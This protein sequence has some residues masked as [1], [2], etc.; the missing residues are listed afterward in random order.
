MVTIAGSDVRAAGIEA[1][2]SW[3]YIIDITFEQ[4]RNKPSDPVAAQRADLMSYLLGAKPNVVEV[5]QAGEVVLSGKLVGI[6]KTWTRVLRGLAELGFES[7][8]AFDKAAS[9]QI[10]SIAPK[11]LQ[12][13]PDAQLA[14]ADVAQLDRVFEIGG[15]TLSAP[16]PAVESLDQRI[17]RFDSLFH[18]DHL[19]GV[20]PEMKNEYESVGA[21]IGASYDMVQI[22]QG[23]AMITTHPA[24]PPGPENPSVDPEERPETTTERGRTGPRG[25]TALINRR[26][27]RR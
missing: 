24:P 8:P 1:A 16:G 21:A 18:G 17:A 14:P 9:M 12:S 15:I 27:F 2:L 23:L 26:F 7:A 20:T 19:R 5:L 10:L 4:F 13:A 6:P 3:V 25:V 22:E 11:Y